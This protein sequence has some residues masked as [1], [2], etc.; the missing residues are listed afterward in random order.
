MWGETA[1]SDDAEGEARDA[2]REYLQG[3]G[4]SH[5]QSAVKI[6]KFCCLFCKMNI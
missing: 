6:V 4:E 5:L 3:S 2:G 1:K